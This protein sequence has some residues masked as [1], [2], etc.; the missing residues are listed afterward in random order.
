VTVPGWLRR[1]GSTPRSETGRQVLT[2]LVCSTLILAAVVSVTIAT[3]LHV[4]FYLV[5]N[6][7]LFADLFD[8]VLRRC[9]IRLHTGSFGGWASQTSVPIDIGE[10]TESQIRLHIKPYAFIVSIHNLADKADDFVEAMLPFRD[11]VWVI[12]DASTDGS[13]AVLLRA[14]FRCV[15]G[16]FNQ[17]KPGAIR[18]LLRHL[19]PE[20]RTV[21][22]MD[23]DCRLADD[24]APEGLER[25]IFEFQ[26]SGMAALTPRIRIS[27][28][29]FWPTMQA[30]EYALTF[31]VL[32]KSL[33]DHCVTSG[34]AIYRRD[35]LEAT[36]D[37]HD[38]SVYAEDFENAVILL[39]EGERIYYDERLVFE[40]SAKPTW[41]DLLS[42]R[43]GWF[44]GLLHVYAT[45]LPRIRSFWRRDL[46]TTYH[47]LVFAGALT[48]VLYPVRLLMLLTIALSIAS[49]FDYVLGLGLIPDIPMA[50]PRHFLFAYLQ[51]TVFMTILMVTGV[52]R[53]E[54]ARLAP[55][56]PLFFFYA[57]ALIVPTTLGYLNWLSLR[58]L[59]RRIYHDHYD[60]RSEARE[61]V[62]VGR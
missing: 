44:F 49:G 30:L 36:L 13:A 58:F 26:R 45:Q 4:L 33:G 35:A 54:R 5:A 46:S 16:A 14:G 40:T 19:D 39:S 55:A 8:F 51:Y 37:K 18:Q 21:I 41:R 6:Y 10:F 34:L 31:S 29:G 25:R 2:A 23:P 56:V 12:D 50:D 28:V 42:Q 24:I 59:G 27:E 20:V 22:V 53:H 7:M 32:R 11:K 1:F 9:L 15:R 48:I 61:P 52:H 60:D 43:V 62:L 47:F 17:K 3:P 57:L 38:L